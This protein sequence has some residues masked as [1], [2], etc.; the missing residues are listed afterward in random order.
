[1]FFDSTESKRKKREHI[2]TEE[3][4]LSTKLNTDSFNYDF[5]LR[6]IYNHIYFQSSKDKD[7]NITYLL[8]RLLSFYKNPPKYA[9][10]YIDAIVLR[11]DLEYLNK[12][13][14]EEFMQYLCSKIEKYGFKLFSQKGNPSIS[15][16]YSGPRNAFYMLRNQ[17]KTARIPYFS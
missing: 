12:V 16:G 7:F 11:V 4:S 15:K 13:S 3:I 9:K 14:D 2:V 17:G 8:K 1:L 5:H 10:N 6:T